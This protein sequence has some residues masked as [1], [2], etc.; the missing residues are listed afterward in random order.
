MS[1][2]LR[3]TESF[4]DLQ[5]IFPNWKVEPLYSI[6]EANGYDVDMTVQ[7]I[8]TIENVDSS[9]NRENRPPRTNQR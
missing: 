9:S 6:F 8:L 7:S 2:S 5:Q 4:K 1:Q 3:E